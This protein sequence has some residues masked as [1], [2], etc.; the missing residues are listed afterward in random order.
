MRNYPLAKFFKFGDIIRDLCLL[1]N[2]SSTVKEQLELR[3]AYTKNYEPK[4]DNVEV[5]TK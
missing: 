4:D 5:V 2:A 1:P 3:W